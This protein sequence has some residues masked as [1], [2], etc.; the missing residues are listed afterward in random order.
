[1]YLSAVAD[2]PFE[3]TF[4]CACTPRVRRNIFVIIQILA[5]YDRHVYDTHIRISGETLRIGQV[6]LER[7]VKFTDLNLSSKY[8]TH[9]D[10]KVQRVQ[11]AFHDSLYLQHT[12]TGQ[13]F[14]LDCS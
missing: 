1:M 4:S 3:F 13:F 9:P 2:L 11:N 6:V 10:S 14:S 7:M 5:I 8:H 12:W